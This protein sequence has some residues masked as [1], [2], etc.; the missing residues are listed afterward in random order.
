MVAGEHGMA[1]GT[2]GKT[3][4]HDHRLSPSLDILDPCLGGGDAWRRHR[5]AL[6]TQRRPADDGR[7][8]ADRA[9]DL[10]FGSGAFHKVDGSGM[11]WT[12]AADGEPATIAHKIG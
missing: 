5:V 10:R 1:R 9:D 8:A 11:R 2:V 7:S 6:L 3:E 12:G 4:G